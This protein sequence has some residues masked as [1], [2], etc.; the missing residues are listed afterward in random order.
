MTH[1]LEEFAGATIGSRQRTPPK[2]KWWGWGWLSAWWGQCNNCESS[3]AREQVGEIRPALIFVDFQFPL[4]AAA[5]ANVAH[6]ESYCLENW[7]QMR[8]RFRSRPD[9]KFSSWR[10]SGSSVS[11]LGMK[12]P[13]FVL[14][15]QGHGGAE[16]LC[17]DLDTS[18]KL[19]ARWQS[20]FYTFFHPL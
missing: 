7:Q 18:D 17:F 19:G 1:K 5:A 11:G 2:R 12:I 16:W 20:G 4:L 3:K 14:F 9:T 13:A 6:C 8:P 10:F 15:W